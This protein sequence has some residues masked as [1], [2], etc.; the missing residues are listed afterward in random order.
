MKNATTS[1]VPFAKNVGVG[2]AVHRHALPDVQ[3]LPLN[4]LIEKKNSF[5]LKRLL[6]DC[7]SP[8]GRHLAYFCYQPTYFLIFIQDWRAAHISQSSF[9]VLET[10][11]PWHWSNRF[12]P[13]L[14]LER[15]ASCW[16]FKGWF[17]CCQISFVWACVPKFQNARHALVAGICNFARWL[18]P[19]FK[20]TMSLRSPSFRVLHFECY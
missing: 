8:T 20:L 13:T 3:N 16:Y 7:R 9:G 12:C 15:A 1:I 4:V 14:S 17:R 10:F 19:C 2:F 18:S 6:P 5:C 11:L